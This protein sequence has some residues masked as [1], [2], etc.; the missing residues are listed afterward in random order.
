MAIN[1]RAKGLRG[2]REIRNLIQELTG[3]RLARNTE[4]SEK[5]GYDLKVDLTGLK[6]THEKL[7]A[8]KFDAFAFEIKNTAREFQH[9]YWV[10]TVEQAVRYARHPVLMYKIPLKGWRV[11]TCL[12][13]LRGEESGRLEDIV[14]TTPEVFLRAV[15]LLRVGEVAA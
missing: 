11:A 1:S 7:L 14:H 15:G 6:T 3:F 5:G 12:Y 13:V 2:E 10:Q 8:L 4:Q 9:A